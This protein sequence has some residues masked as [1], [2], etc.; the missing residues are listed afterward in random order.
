[1]KM[2]ITQTV[3]I[4]DR[5]EMYHFLVVHAS[6]IGVFHFGLHEMKTKTRFCDQMLPII[7]MARALSIER[8]ILS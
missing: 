4:H 8:Y 7:S 6:R 5:L 1:M 2:M 3:A